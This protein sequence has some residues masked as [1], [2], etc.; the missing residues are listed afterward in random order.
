[1]DEA[2]DLVKFHTQLIDK[3]DTFRFNIFDLR[4]IDISCIQDTMFVEI[5]ALEY[6]TKGQML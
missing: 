6:I 4:R 3:L 1:M 2:Y 5:E